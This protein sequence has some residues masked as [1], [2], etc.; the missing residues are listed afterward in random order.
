MKMC[1]RGFSLLELAV[2]VAAATVI[3]AVG[4][5]TRKAMLQSS[6]TRQT[7]KEMVAIRDAGLSYY[8]KNGA[9]PSAFSELS[10]YMPAKLVSAPTNPYGFSYTFAATGFRFDVSTTIPKSAGG[11]LGMDQISRTAGVTNDTLT[12]S[13]VVDMGNTGGA[14]YEKDKGWSG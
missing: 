11:D 3:I 12:L 6:Y 14:F 4:L 13:G 7:G 10:G 9:F 2:A 1:Q 8:W 5:G